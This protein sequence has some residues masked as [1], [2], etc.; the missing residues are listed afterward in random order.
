MIT[1][2][3]MIE[4]KRSRSSEHSVIEGETDSSVDRLKKSFKMSVCG[5]VKK[6]KVPDWENVITA[7]PVLGSGVDLL[8]EDVLN[9]SSWCLA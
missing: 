6:G 1:A 8:F 2:V 7:T 5:A 9:Q 4:R 3:D